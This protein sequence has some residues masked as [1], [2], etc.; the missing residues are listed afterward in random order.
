MRVKL[1]CGSYYEGV[2]TKYFETNLRYFYKLLF[3]GTWEI[4]H[5]YIFRVPYKGF[6]T[7]I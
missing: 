7:T 6:G 2:M 3:S 1:K 4:L 5:K